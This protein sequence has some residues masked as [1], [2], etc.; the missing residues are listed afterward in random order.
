M[1]LLFTYHNNSYI[2][3]GGGSAW[4]AGHWTTSCWSWV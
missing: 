4:T 3:N 2:I 1:L